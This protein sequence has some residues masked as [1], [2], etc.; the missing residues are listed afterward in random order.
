MEQ[1]YE[2]LK[3]LGLLAAEKL[4]PT[5]SQGQEQQRTSQEMI[6]DF[7]GNTDQPRTTPEG[8]EMKMLKVGIIVGSTR[9]DGKPRPSQSGCTTS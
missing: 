1:L 9:P 2:S 6:R 3:K 5:R 8:R 4:E 7:R